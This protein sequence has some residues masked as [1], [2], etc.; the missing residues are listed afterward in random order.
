MSQVP[1]PSQE[2]PEREPVEDAH[3]DILVSAVRNL[4][5]ECDEDD[6][7]LRSAIWGRLS[8]SKIA[9]GVRFVGGRP[10]GYAHFAEAEAPL[11]GPVTI[12]PWTG[13][14]H[15]RQICGDTATDEALAVQGEP[16]VVCALL[17]PTTRKRI[18]ELFKAEP[19]PISLRIEGSRVTLRGPETLALTSRRIMSDVLG[20]LELVG[21]SRV[22][23]RGL[24][25]RMVHNALEDPVSEVRERNA[26]MLGQVMSSADEE[27]RTRAAQRLLLSDQV[28]LDHRLDIFRMVRGM[29]E[30]RVLPLM[31]SLLEDGPQE[32]A[33]RA[34]TWAEEVK[35]A[36][37]VRQLLRVLRRFEEPT[38]VR[39]V[40]TALCAIEDPKSQATLLKLLER[41]DEGLRVLIIEGLGR[42][43]T[44][45]A[46]API[47][48]FTK[49]L[50]AD[51]EI[52]RSAKQALER[53]KAR[54]SLQD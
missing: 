5:M 32:L 28:S 39:G 30:T 2:Y 17:D 44:T 11:I 1:G 52:K 4:G 13:Q 9:V 35:S 10:V 47:L 24:L 15:L 18:V 27:S 25:E 43:G 53:I 31:Q 29:P 49:G 42:F 48:P 12:E 23:T 6:A 3:I 16:S 51:R 22:G 54:A 33:R 38:I 20:L 21:T 40:V 19:P 7:R 8:G 34:V 50:F 41:E 46:V 26:D 14:A 36:D 45:D 37:S